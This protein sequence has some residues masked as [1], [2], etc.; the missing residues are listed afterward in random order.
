MSKDKKLENSRQILMALFCDTGM[1]ALSAVPVMAPNSP[2]KKFTGLSGYI[3]RVAKR[4]KQRDNERK[5]STY[6]VQYVHVLGLCIPS[7]A[8]FHG[9]DKA[10]DYPGFLNASSG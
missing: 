9:H 8:L 7:S 10:K 3:L 4:T 5:S 2:N 1:M 6:I